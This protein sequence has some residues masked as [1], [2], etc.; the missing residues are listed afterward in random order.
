MFDDVLAG[1]VHAGESAAG[2]G[3]HARADDAARRAAA[4]DAPIDRRAGT[5]RFFDD[6]DEFA[7]NRFR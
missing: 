2:A 7:T 3:R 6:V 4:V 1:F 5:C